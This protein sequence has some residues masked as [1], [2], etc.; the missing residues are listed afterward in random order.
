MFKHP[1]VKFSLL[2]GVATLVIAS[3]AYSEI[4]A[5]VFINEIPSP[6]YFNDGDS[7]RVF[8]GKL[9]GTKARLSQVQQLKFWPCT[10]MGRLARKELYFNAKMR[11]RM[12]RCVVL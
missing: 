12:P 1:P 10:P 5:K 11:H 6:V 8:C 7:F 2:F 3:I 9:N 4:R